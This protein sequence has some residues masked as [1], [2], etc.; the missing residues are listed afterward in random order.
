MGG[1]IACNRLRGQSMVVT[2]PKMVG[3]QGTRVWTDEIN[4]LSA[5]GS[6]I[7][8]EIENSLL[9]MEVLETEYAP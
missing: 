5:Q 8:S 2:G 4:V 3:F 9:D 7:S 1:S 6:H